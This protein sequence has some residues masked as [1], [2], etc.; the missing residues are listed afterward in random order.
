MLDFKISQERAAVEMEVVRH[1]REAKR[2]ALEDRSIHERGT[3]IG[4]NFLLLSL[5]GKGGFS[6]VT[7]RPDNNR[8]ISRSRVVLSLPIC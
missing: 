6:E 8:Q 7:E 1:R 3:I 4:K 2:C 5:L